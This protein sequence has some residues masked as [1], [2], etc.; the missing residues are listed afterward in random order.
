MSY[1]TERGFKDTMDTEKTT[2]MLRSQFQDICYKIDKERIKVLFPEKIVD[3]ADI[4]EIA[5]KLARTVTTTLRFYRT[6]SGSNME[7]DEK[8]ESDLLIFIWMLYKK[9]INL[10]T[11]ILWHL[12]WMK[13]GL[14]AFTRWLDTFPAS[15]RGAAADSLKKPDKE[16]TLEGSEFI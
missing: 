5:A 7:I 9:G 11:S 15:A 1:N 3:G 14:P 4:G 16:K 2:R 6:Q 12:E 10:D 13:S 8:A